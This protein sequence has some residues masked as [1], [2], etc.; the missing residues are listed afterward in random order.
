MLLSLSLVI[1]FLR[2][3]FTIFILEKLLSQEALVTGSVTAINS[4]LYKQSKADL[5]GWIND[6]NSNNDVGGWG[7]FWSNFLT[8][9]SSCFQSLWLTEYDKANDFK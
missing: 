4:N 2:N 5:Y 8:K 3:V 9:G 7:S 1:E 6:K